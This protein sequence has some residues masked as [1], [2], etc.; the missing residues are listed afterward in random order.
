MNRLMTTALLIGAGMAAQNYI[1]KN[2]LMSSRQMKK[3][4]N[5]IVRSFS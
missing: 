4:Q 2:D 5:R 3:L 1:Q